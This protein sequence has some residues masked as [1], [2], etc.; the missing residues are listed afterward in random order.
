MSKRIKQANVNA[1]E[2]IYFRKDRVLIVK[3]KERPTR[4]PV[5]LISTAFHA[6][7]AHVISRSGN[8]RVKP[9][10]IKH[11]NQH[12]GGVDS[13]DKSVPCDLYTTNQAVLEEE[14]LQFYRYGHS[15]LICPVQIPFSKAY[16]QNGLYEFN[17]ERSS[18]R[19]ACCPWPS[20]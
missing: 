6:E 19:T 11:Y 3:Y 2:S 14:C 13:K 12:M 9:V 20:R 16:E 18:F 10:V 17:C 1:G 5:L 4:K 8:D 7:D 15:K